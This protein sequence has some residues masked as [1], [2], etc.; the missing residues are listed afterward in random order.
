M[1]FLNYLF[2]VSIILLIGKLSFA[3]EI[4]QTIRGRVIDMQSQ[5]SLPGAN[6]IILDIDPPKGTITDAQGYFEIKNIKTGRI[7]IR[8]SYMGYHPVT[9]TNQNLTSGKE[10]VLNIEMEEQ[11]IKTE[12][13]V[14]KAN[15][16]KT[17]TNNEMT[18]NS[19]RTF[20]IE[21]TQRYAGARNDV[22][23]MATNYAG[24][25]T[26]NDA[27]NDII[28]RGNSPNGLLW[29]LE[30]VEIPNPN[31]FGSMGGTGGPVS[32]LNNNVLSNSDF[33]TAAFPAEYGNALSGVFDLKMRNGNYEKYEFIGQIGFNGFEFGAEGPI[34]RKNRSSFLLNYRYST[35]GLI[36]DMGVDFG[37]GTAVPK[38]QD[39][40]FKIHNPTNKFGTFNL[41]GLWGKSAI[42]FIKDEESSDGLYGTDYFDIYNWNDQGIIGLSHSYIFNSSTY[43][44][45][46]IS[47]TYIDNHSNL[48]SVDFEN[49]YSKLPY[50]RLT[51]SNSRLTANFFIN[52]KFGA[53]NN[54]RIGGI[55]N[56]L[57]YNLQDSTYF[58][59]DDKFYTLLNE[60]NNS[61]LIQSYL[62]W[63]FKPSDELIFNTGVHYLYFQL[64]GNYSI[65]PRAG[66]KW[67]FAPRQSLS[68]AYG[69][70][71][72]NMPLY[73]YFYNERNNDGSIT[74]ADKNVDF[75]KSHHLVLGYDWNINKTLR[76]KLETYYQYIYDA[77]VEK[78]PSA[79]SMLNLSSV[80]FTIPS[81]LKN[82]GTGTNYGVELTFEKFLDK[83][84]Y[85]LLTT[86]L[87]E[88]K[89]VGS[90]GEERRT[91][92]DSKYVVNFLGGK[93]W[94][95]GK[96]KENKRNRKWISVDARITAAGG[97]LYTP[98]DVQRTIAL[99][100]TY[101]QESNPYSKQFDDYFR[102]DLRIAFRIDGKRLSQE[103]AFDIQ[104]ITN[105][106][107]PLY[108]EFDLKEQKEVP[109][110]QLGI[111]PMLQ[112]RIMF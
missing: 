18:T 74:Y 80:I 108:M 63:Q 69:L 49:N 30:G 53:K 96:N 94:E 67:M 19:S 97:Q 20:T 45:F 34:S 103:W 105:K 42:E 100:S 73:Y 22:S 26:A 72:K 98:I 36:S 93:E 112:Y 13:I 77:V 110:N 21:E 85:F 107:N 12:E 81:G 11:I 86:S 48:D 33:M 32:M 62:Q 6:V 106:K 79:F 75:T 88:S 43:T 111:F 92:F 17:K 28:I 56:R 87:F 89:Y 58:A 60:K 102:A 55:Y 3:Q 61:G 40:S 9:L 84:L 90:N 91:A 35:L 52:K 4:T 39:L 78:E 70:H 95:L 27:V 59:R 68:F 41:F 101:Y 76:L 71:S 65:E 15:R 104:N 82:G 47:G 38:Y 51:F 25:N 99:Q 37:T 2:F 23:R 66:V 57:Y 64:N 44:R 31:H 14:V 1:K 10:M 24:V 8:I 83:G 109:V 5:V 16:D 46:I 50:K 54:I 29:R 7:N